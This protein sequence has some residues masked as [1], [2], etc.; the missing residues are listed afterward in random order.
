MSKTK[1][2]KKRVIAYETFERK[3]AKQISVMVDHILAKEKKLVEENYDDLYDE[4]HEEA[5]YVLADE[6]NVV[7]E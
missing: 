1:K 3:Y 5:V 6:K 4:A 2:S 7:L